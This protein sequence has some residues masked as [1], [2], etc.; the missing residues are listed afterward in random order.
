[1]F[2][3]F[4]LRVPTKIAEVQEIKIYFCSSANC[5]IS[6]LSVYLLQIMT[7]VPYN[8]VNSHMN[9]QLHSDLHDMVCRCYETSKRILP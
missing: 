9:V 1:M 8:L 3:T 7:I 5:L 4:S 2:T 6:F